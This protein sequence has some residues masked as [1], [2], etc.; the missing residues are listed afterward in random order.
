MRCIERFLESPH[1]VLIAVRKKL[2]K[3]LGRYG[4]YGVEFLFLILTLFFAN[5]G[6][7]SAVV[8]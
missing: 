4:S 2:R 7:I 8:F 1:P 3:V 6:M 5:A